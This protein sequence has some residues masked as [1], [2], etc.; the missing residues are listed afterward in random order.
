MKS[1]RNKSKIIIFVVLL[2]SI[3]LGYAFINSDLKLSGIATVTKQRWNVYFDNLVV[4]EGSVTPVTAASLSGEY[5]TTVAYSVSLEKPGDYYEFTVDAVNSGSIDAMVDMVSITDD[6]NPISLPSYIE[7]KVEKINGH[8]IEEGDI[9]LANDTKKYKVRVYFKQ[10]IEKE[11][12]ENIEPLNLK[13]KFEVVYAQ[14]TKEDLPKATSFATD[15]W[16]TIAYEGEKA[17]K[18]T[19]VTNNKC[20]A[21]NVGDTKTIQM[22]ADNNGTPEEYTLRIA[23][24]STPAICSTPGFSQTACGF[25]VEFTGLISYQQYNPQQ[26]ND[27]ING[28]S[29]RG[30]WKYSHLRAYLNGGVYLKDDPTNEIDYRDNGIIDFLPNDLRN[31]I[32]PTIAV[33][34]HGSKDTENFT[35]TDKLYLLSTHEIWEDDDEDPSSGIDYRDTAYSNTRQL[36]Y[37]EGLGVTVRN[38]SGADKISA[39]GYSF[40]WW[41]RS[42]NIVNSSYC[43]RVD[44]GGGASPSTSSTSNAGVSPAFRL[45]N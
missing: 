21:Y 38:K 40:R 15:D 43:F 14:A 32:I 17:A 30:G 35:S 36:D 19:S 2:L 20:G 3:S 39:S 10:D 16:K 22:D 24:C 13:L 12:L 33:S 1:N 44:E 42:V 26:S 41:T 6:G 11:E 31:S 4:T 18:Q 37:Y 27:T 45:A 25:V 7:Y 23:N 28:Y 34:G 5:P 9:L 29:N 8:G